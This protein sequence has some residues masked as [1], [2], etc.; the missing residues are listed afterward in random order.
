[1]L[2]VVVTFFAVLGLIG[3]YNGYN[4]AATLVAVHDGLMIASVVLGVVALESLV[5]ALIFRFGRT[6]KRAAAKR[7]GR[8]AVAAAACALGCLF[9]GA[10]HSQAVRMMYVLVPLAAALYIIRLTYKREFYLI[11]LMLALS[12]VACWSYRNLGAWYP[13]LSASF[14][15]VSLAF[16]LSVFVAYRV[17]V[18]NQGVF[19]LGPVKLRFDMNDR[20]VPFMEITCALTAA[21]AV[22]CLVV[23]ASV[24]YYA[25]YVLLGYTFV[26]AAYYTVRLM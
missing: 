22:L 6:Q 2:T 23:G 25:V 17:A 9:M 7:S 11:S 5:A 24:A 13:G 1:M 18:K 10:L 3:L 8:I 16:A 12:G 19:A 15:D 20:A 14:S 26:A 21:A 4:R